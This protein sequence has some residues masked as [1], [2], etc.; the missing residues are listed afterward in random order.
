VLILLVGSANCPELEQHEH[1][2]ITYEHSIGCES[3]FQII[4]P[5]NVDIA[6]RKVGDTKLAKSIISN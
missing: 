5:T 6:C 3:F 2:H 1:D 4:E